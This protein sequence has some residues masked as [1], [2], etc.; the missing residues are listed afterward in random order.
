MEV[1]TKESTRRA[2]I[3]LVMHHAQNG[4]CLL[5]EGP[6]QAPSKLMSEQPNRSTIEHV[7]P[8]SA[9][10]RDVLSNMALSHRRCNTERGSR[11]L[12]RVQ[13]H[14]WTEIQ[15]RRQDLLESM[16]ISA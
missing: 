10:G 8:T 9:G 6:M 4:R 13:A 14:F 5:C 3:F 15:A 11:P 1:A 12:D 2:I 7:I 16:G